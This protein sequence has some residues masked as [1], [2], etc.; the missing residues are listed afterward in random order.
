GD[1]RTDPDIKGYVAE[2][3]KTQPATWQTWY[4]QRQASALGALE[5]SAATKSAVHADTPTVAYFDTLG[6]TFL[7]VAHNKFERKKADG[8]IETGEG[9]YPTWMHLDI[10]GNQRE[11]WD[12]WTNEQNN[13]EQRI[14]MRYDFD[15]LGNRIRQA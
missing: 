4:T 9:Q 8:T 5:Q 2:Y 11:V 13:L 10:E 14:V 6:R 3:F 7:T 1:P 15:M 12:E